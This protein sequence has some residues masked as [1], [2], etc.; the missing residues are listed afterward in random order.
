MERDVLKD[1]QA[2]LVVDGLLI[3]YKEYLDLRKEMQKKLKVSAG[4]AFAKG[5]FIDDG[6]A[7]N[8]TSFM[9]YKLEKAGESWEYLEFSFG[10]SKPSL[11]I[12]KNDYRLQQTFSKDKKKKTSRYLSNYAKINKSTLDLVRRGQRK[13]PNVSIQLELSIDEPFI[14]EE[15]LSKYENFYIVVYKTD[16]SKVIESVLL[17]LPDDETRVLHMIQDLSPY[18]QTTSITIEDEEYSA[19]VGEREEIVEVY[20]YDY[21]VPEEDKETSNE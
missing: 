3:G 6:V 2:Q 20:D 9:D 10:E 7:K 13:V 4:F 19:V 8:T 21:T 15:E 11:F 1:E 17:V 5:N 14:S 18:L 16:I 12:I